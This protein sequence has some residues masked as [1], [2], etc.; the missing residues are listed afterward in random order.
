MNQFQK[1]GSDFVP[2]LQATIEQ[3]VEPETGVRHVHLA[4]SREEL[5][6][7]VSFPTVPMVS[8]GRAHI[9]EHLALCGSQAY[10]VADPF[11]S[12]M[13]RSTATFMNAMTYPDR[14]V[15]PFASTDKRDFFNLLDVYLDAAFFPKLDYLSFRQEGWRYT[16][17]EGRLAYQGVVFNEMKGTLDNPMR[18]LQLGIARLLF[19]GETYAFDSGG[20]PL[21]IPNLT[22]QKL[23]EFHATH[24]HPSQAIFMTAGSVPA[25]EIQARIAGRVLSRTAGKTPPRI[26]GLAPGWR[27]P[28]HVDVLVPSQESRRD[29]F[30]IQFAWLLGES[31]DPKAATESVLLMQGLLGDPSAPLV[32]AMQSAGFG[33]PS[34][35]NGASNEAR[36]IVFHLGM[37]GL[38]EEQVDLARTLIVDTIKRTSLVGVPKSTLQSALRD[39]RFEQREVRGGGMPDG[40]SRLLTALPVMMYGGDVLTAFGNDALFDALDREIDD[41][42]YFRGLVSQLIHNQTCLVTRVVADAQFFARRDLVEAAQL[43]EHAAQMSETDRLELLRESAALEAWQ[44]R[45]QDTDALPRIRPEDVNPTS[46]PLTALHYARHGMV[47]AEI[48]SNGIVYADLFFDVSCFPENE[49]AWLALYAE[50]VPQLGV[51]KLGFAEAGAW[52]Q[53]LVPR[54]GLSFEGHLRSQDFAPT[55]RFHAT[56]LGEEKNS[57]AEVLRA[58]TGV[59]RFD[60]WDRIRFLVESSIEK[61]LSTLSEAGSQYAML[62]A[63]A[64]LSQRRRFQDAT[65]GMSSLSFC[66]TLR[67]MLAS[68]PEAIAER[69]KEMHRQIVACPRT[70]L[71]SGLRDDGGQLA[72][73]IH[74]PGEEI[75]AIAM[76][77]VHHET[78]TPANLALIVSSQVNHCVIAWKGPELAGDDA[79]ALAVAAEL[80]TNTIL[81]QSLREKGG[82]YGGS[83]AYSDEDGIFTMSSYRDPRLAETY[84]DFQIALDRVVVES[85]AEEAMEEAKICVIKRLDKPLSPYQETVRS[86]AFQQRGVT[87]IQRQEFRRGVLGCT[88]AEVRSAVGRWLQPGLA[89]RAA[90]VGSEVRVLGGLQPVSLIALAG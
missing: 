3:Y 28:R 25:A 52:R 19:E 67:G 74:L 88:F 58:W 23:Q 61:K 72:N 54:F 35:L 70:V 33:R 63:S 77:E 45:A 31:A 69:L 53:S 49:W 80:L 42:E 41:P 20:D 14:T 1:T 21:I 85:F 46:T 71:C 81:H 76:P 10:P 59:V 36:Q 47:I 6:F 26:P 79:P 13:R 62:A 56:G 65:G 11:F 34:Q 87:T 12:M 38:T 86:W 60:E 17:E 2:V 22:H 9:L 90:V 84:A 30:G 39:L 78:G 27:A 55:I 16:L 48:A 44:N 29:D 51:G 15:Y 37:E 83:A 68:G 82:A 75:E 43:A 50:L 18:A 7:L 24:Y 64:P 73:L 66:A 40:L 32:A 57:V 8:D 89:S 5:A 4:N